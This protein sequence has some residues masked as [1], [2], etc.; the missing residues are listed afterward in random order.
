MG[1]L[2]AHM[3][4]AYHKNSKSERRVKKVKNKIKIIII[5]SPE[6]AHAKLRAEKQQ[7]KTVYKISELEC[8]GGDCNTLTNTD[9]E[10]TLAVP[11]RSFNRSVSGRG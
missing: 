6:R 5:N 4:A 3:T 1:K 9:L 11:N 10:K 8:T 2:C 7:G